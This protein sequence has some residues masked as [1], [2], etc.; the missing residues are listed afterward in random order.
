MTKVYHP[1]VA[2]G[3]WN[4]MPL[5]TFPP[6]LIVKVLIVVR[7]PVESSHPTYAFELA[8]KLHGLLQL[9]VTVTPVAPTV[10]VDLPLACVTTPA[11]Y[12][13]VS[14]KRVLSSYMPS[15]AKNAVNG[16]ISFAVSI[17]SRHRGGP[18]PPI[19]PGQVGGARGAVAPKYTMALAL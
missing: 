7:C 17:M 16:A 1:G 6:P 9:A 5:G 14:P 18:E 15:S 19:P 4:V 11:G 10:G 13:T 2:V 12:G 8:L 3:T